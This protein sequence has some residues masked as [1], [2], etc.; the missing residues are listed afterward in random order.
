MQTNNDSHKVAQPVIHLPSN[1]SP[2]EENYP[3][4]VAN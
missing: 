3:K 1:I 2:L 4:Q